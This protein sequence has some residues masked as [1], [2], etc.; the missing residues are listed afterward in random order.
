M[1]RGNSCQSGHVDFYPPQFDFLT[2]FKTVWAYGMLFG[3]IKLAART[4]IAVLFKNLYRAS[5]LV[6][7]YPG[8]RC[9]Q[10]TQHKSPQ[11]KEP[12]T[13]RKVTHDDSGEDIYNNEKNKVHK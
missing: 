4:F 3:K 9:Q 13:V 1:F 12:L 6:I 10:D 2:I 5:A 8:N 7:Q 11:P